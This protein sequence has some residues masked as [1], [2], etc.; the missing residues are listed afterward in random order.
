MENYKRFFAFGC[1]FTKY[2]WPTWADILG[3][4]FKERH[5][6]GYEGVGNFYIFKTIMEAITAH[7]I[8]G[9]DLVIVQWSGLTRE[10]RYIKGKWM[11]NGNIFT[12][13]I[14]DK[15][16]LENYT[17]VEHFIFRDITLIAAAYELLEKTKCKFIFT[18][19][20]PIFE[21]ENKENN[22]IQF[23]KNSS[24]NIKKFINLYKKYINF[25]LPSFKE[26]IFNNEWP[27]R[28]DSHPTTSEHLLFVRKILIPN[29]DSDIII[30]EKI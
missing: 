24:I 3:K 12:S 13:K 8:N 10:D 16:F 19:M 17:D 15:N 4:S 6:Y 28:T 18:S 26:V 21:Y 7:K 20:S 11:C 1:S 23:Q 5:N 29:I 9:D 14:Y 25:F 2:K 30:D 27:S 22:T